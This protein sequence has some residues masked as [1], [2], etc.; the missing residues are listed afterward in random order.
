MQNMSLKLFA[1]ID[2]NNFFVS[3]ER[4]FRPDLNLR[5]VIVLSNNDGCVVSRSNE[6][7]TLGIPMGIPL[8][9]CKDIVERFNI[10]VFSS[11]FALYGDISARVMKILSYFAEDIEI[12]SIDE[13]FLSLEKTLMEDPLVYAKKIKE[14]ILKYT[15]VPVSIGL[16]RTKTLAKAASKIAKKQTDGTFFITEENKKNYLSKFS[17]IDIWGIGYKSSNKLKQ[18]GIFTAADFLNAEK[19]IIKKI[20]G[21]TGERIWLEISGISSIPISFQQK[22]KHGILNSRSFG[23]PVT[24][25]AELSEA[26]S[27]FTENAAV[28]LRKENAAASVVGVFVRSSKHS[29][30]QYK[31]FSYCTLSSP[32]FFTP[33]LIGAAI[34]TLKQIYKPRI[35]YKKCGV[36]FTGIAPKG[37][38]QI[39]IFSSDQISSEYEKHKNLMDSI[40]KINMKTGN[41]IF[42]AAQGVK[43]R[44]KSNRKNL[45][46]LYTTNWEEIPVIS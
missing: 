2:C 22:T 37:E 23:T 40:D 14:T 31:N 36:F 24:S 42:F 46:P 43:K 25:F 34:T 39:G 33:H 13:A 19:N 9:D 15:G 21:V 6:A 30:E 12:Y 20:M 32:T 26:V 44:W 27:L 17:A 7:K 3:C 28:S 35:K 16:G 1:L 10:T 29:P 38:E 45:S 5:P 8:F 41:R 11:N 4:I 18:I